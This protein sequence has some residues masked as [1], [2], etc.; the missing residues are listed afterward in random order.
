MN[1]ENIIGDYKKF[2]VKILSN[3]DNADINFYSYRFSE[4]DHIAY[5]VESNESYENKKKELDKIGQNISE[6]KVR[7]RFISIFKLNQPIIYG[8]YKIPSIE[9]PAPKKDSDYKEGLEHAEMVVSK[10]LQ[11]IMDERKDLDWE[12]KR[13]ESHNP[14]LILKFDDGLTVKFHNQSIE[15][16]I[17]FEKQN[18]IT[19]F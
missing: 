13:P 18:N 3:L 9:L 4:I 11:E 10:S 14:E 19:D 12:L 2:L 7:G 8:T 1:I 6:I 17:E 15:K 5:R 16:I